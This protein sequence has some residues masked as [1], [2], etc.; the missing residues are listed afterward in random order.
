MPPAD[1]PPHEMLAGSVRNASTKSGS[2]RYGEVAGTWRPRKTGSSLAV[3]VELWSPVPHEA[4]TA[5]AERLAA[6]RGVVLKDVHI[7]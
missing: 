6:F 7:D 2:V 3:A 1:P 5:A 4:L